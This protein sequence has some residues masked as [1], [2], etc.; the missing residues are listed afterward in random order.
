[1][2]KYQ[3]IILLMIALAILLIVGGLG[4]LKISAKKIIDEKTLINNNNVSKDFRDTKLGIFFSYPA[5]WEEVLLK[6]MSNSVYPATGTIISNTKEI[7]IGN[8]RLHLSSFSKDYKSYVNPVAFNN[9]KINVDWNID[10]FSKNMNISKS[11]IFFVKKLNTKSVLVALFDNQEGDPSLFLTLL[12][13]FNEN[14]PNFK[15][16]IAYPFYNDP[17]VEKYKQSPEYAKNNYDL[18]LP[19]KE[20]ANNIYNGNISEE[21]AKDIDIASNI[22]N[23]FEYSQPQTAYNSQPLNSDKEEKN[24]ISTDTLLNKLL[25]GLSFRDGIAYN[26]ENYKFYLK[27]RIE[28]Y[29][30]NTNEKSLLITIANQYGEG[31]DVGIF[32]KKGN[33]LMRNDPSFKKNVFDGNGIFSL[34]DCSGIKYLSYFS[35]NCPTG[36]CCSDSIKLFKIYNGE[37][38]EIQYINNNNI[39]SLSSS[40]PIVNAANGPLFGLKIT[41]LNEEIVIEKIPATS[42][43]GCTPINYKK[44][45]W[46]ANT[47]QFE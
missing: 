25:P 34:Y 7:K 20:I 39:D 40:F 31:M 16:T 5:D 46:N 11:S 44:L 13:P 29:F 28:D 8:T 10:Q 23:S 6:E 30:I 43:D 18:Y 1:M 12:T 4:Y 35:T 33:L 26:N 15:I 19:L 21:L 3:K 2:N 24:S 42:E 17:I 9:T 47:C 14:Y 36:S 27:D 41:P 22:M 37:F 45:K 32:D 38:K